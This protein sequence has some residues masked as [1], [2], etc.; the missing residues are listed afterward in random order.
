MAKA[1]LNDQTRCDALKRAV[2]TLGPIRRGSLVRRFMPCRKPGCCCR[3]S[4]PDLHGPYYQWTR[5]VRG[6]TVTVRLTREE[7]RLFAEWISNG[8]QLDKIVAQMEAVSLRITQ[9]LVKQFQKPWRRCARRLRRAPRVPRDL[10]EGLYERLTS[11]QRAGVRNVGPDLW[12]V[13]SNINIKVIKEKTTIHIKI[14]TVSPWLPI[15]IPRV[16][17]HGDRLDRL[18]PK[19]SST[20]L[21]DLKNPGI[22]WIL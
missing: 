2:L 21:Y 15:C 11:G 19:G 18:F 13:G 4:P 9:P 12:K 6:K 7:A 8:R 5:K 14:I 16:E 17:P 20:Y 3:A 22:S 10:P 1:S